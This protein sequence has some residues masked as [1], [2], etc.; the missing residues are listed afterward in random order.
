MTKKMV[1]SN[2]ILSSTN[3]EDNND[4]TKNVIEYTYT[5]SDNEMRFAD[6]D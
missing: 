2:Q 3:I 1:I 4:A 5:V 6:Y